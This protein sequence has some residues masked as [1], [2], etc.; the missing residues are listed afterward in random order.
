MML[1]YILFCVQSQFCRQL[2]CLYHATT[3]G[4]AKNPIVVSLLI[5]SSFLLDIVK[6][7]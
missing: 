3:L 6:E 5:F 7:G 1:V 4:C 2:F